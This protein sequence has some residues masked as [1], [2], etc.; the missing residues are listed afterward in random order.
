MAWYFFHFVG[1]QSAE[2]FFG[3]PYASEHEAKEFGELLA[4]D[5]QRNM[6]DV[7][8][9]SYIS[10]TDEGGREISQILLSTAH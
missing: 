5:F 1:Q 10:V 4:W 2:K 7:C 8:A 6:P 3:E 9:G